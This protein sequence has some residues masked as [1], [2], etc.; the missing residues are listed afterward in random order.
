MRIK[1]TAPKTPPPKPSGNARSHPRTPEAP[2]PPT[3]QDGWRPITLNE[4]M[5]EIPQSLLELSKINSSSPILGKSIQGGVAS[6]ALLRSIQCFHDAK[7][8]EEVL[9]GTSSA[10]LAVSG[11][12]TLLPMASA[13]LV[14]HG[15]LLVHGATEMALG[16]REVAEELKKDKPAKLELAAGVL[17]AVKGASTFLPMVF[18]QTA[19]AVNLF[20]IGAI[21]TKTVMEPFMER[22]HPERSFR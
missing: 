17:D 10:A 16:V 14:S 7:S 12:A 8:L 21:A 20:Q 18:P 13:G 3:V 15:A 5:V 9:E 4:A 22:S 11:A 19:D 2:P 6:L 1:V